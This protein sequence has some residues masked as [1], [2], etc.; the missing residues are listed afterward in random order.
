MPEV[1]R[2]A[3]WRSAFCMRSRTS[4]AGLIDTACN[5][6]GAAGRAHGIASATPARGS[7]G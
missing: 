4:S 3:C 2:A 1:A 6:L 7:N 5:A